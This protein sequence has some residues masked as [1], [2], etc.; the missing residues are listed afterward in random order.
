MSGVVSVKFIGPE[1]E[2]FRIVWGGQPPLTN[3]IAGAALCLLNIYLLP[4]YSFSP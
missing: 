1:R 2:G 4:S 3:Y